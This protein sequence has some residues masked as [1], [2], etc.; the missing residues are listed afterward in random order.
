M[1]V[2]EMQGQ[3]DCDSWT[4]E[5]QTYLYC[6]LVSPCLQRN[7]R[8]INNWQFRWGNSKTVKEKA[9]RSYLCVHTCSIWRSKPMTY[10]FLNHDPPKFLD[11]APDWTCISWTNWTGWL[12][13]KPHGSACLC[14]LGAR[15]TDTC[16]YVQLLM[17][18]LG[19]KTQ[20]SCLDS[21]HFTNWAISLAKQTNKQTN[22]GSMITEPNSL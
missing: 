8:V 14:L 6:Y 11:K 13:G 2:L 18:V 7:I 16:R 1:L 20:S 9:L 12:V 17:W 4:R 3:E 22:N 5:F 21:K 19:V 15:A 10:V